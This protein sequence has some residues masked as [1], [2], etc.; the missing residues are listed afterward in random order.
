MYVEWIPH[1]ND[2]CESAFRRPKGYTIK[3]VSTD[4]GSE[5]ITTVE[6]LDLERLLPDTNVTLSNGLESNTKYNI[7]VMTR[8]AINETEGTVNSDASQVYF[9][10]TGRC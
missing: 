9:G 6:S 1:C 7:S 8:I 2:T 5:F 4:G 10:I 3:Y